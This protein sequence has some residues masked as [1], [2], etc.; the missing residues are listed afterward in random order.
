MDYYCAARTATARSER[1]AVRTKA[2]QAKY[3]LSRRF[4]WDAPPSMNASGRHILFG[5]WN[6]PRRRSEV[7]IR[8]FGKGNSASESLQRRG[9]V[10]RRPLTFSTAW[11]S[12]PLNVARMSAEGHSCASLAIV[13]QAGIHFIW[14][15][16]QVS[17]GGWVGYYCV[18]MCTC[19]RG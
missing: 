6:F 10:S 12:I 1:R 19:V 3:C 14:L 16:G 15:S 4:E 18:H 7:T 9:R 2:A 8:K 5:K 13:L 17:V 11:S